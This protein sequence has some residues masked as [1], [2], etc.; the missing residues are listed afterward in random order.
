MWSYT[1]P[2]LS[3][4][5]QALSGGLTPFLQQQ[6][7][8][9]ERLRNHIMDFFANNAGSVKSYFMLWNAHKAFLLSIFSQ[10][11]ARFKRQRQQKLTELTDQIFYL[12]TQNKQKPTRPSPTN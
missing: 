2:T 5:S 8:T 11:G 4:L 3:P 12:E 6:N 1:L 10:L 9:K 7:E